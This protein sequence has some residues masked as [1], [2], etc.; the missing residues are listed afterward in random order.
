MMKFFRVGSMASLVLICLS[1]F[2]FSAFSD[3]EARDAQIAAVIEDQISAFKSKDGERAFSH[4]SPKIKAIFK[5]EKR[6][7]AMV[8]QTYDMIYNPVFHQLEELKDVNGTLVQRAIFVGKKQQTV[9][10]YYEMQKQ[11]DGSWKINGVFVEKV[12]DQVT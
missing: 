11:E 1:I 12:A 10:A 4:A 3:D 5:D 2:S 6:F 8:K 7:N 9:R